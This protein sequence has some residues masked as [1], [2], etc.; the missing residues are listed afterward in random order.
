MSVKNVG[1]K[2]RKNL[3][4]EKVIANELFTLVTLSKELGVNEKTIER[5]IE[6]LKRAG[7]IRFVGPKRS[8]LYK[9]LKKC[10][11]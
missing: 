6:E 3:I 2:E 7:K 5:D 10:K 8:G 4:L 11:K 9:L 1:K